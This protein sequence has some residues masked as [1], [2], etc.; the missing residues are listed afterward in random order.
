MKVRTILILLISLI[1][2]LF[3]YFYPSN[4]FSSNNTSYE[5]I[6]NPLDELNGVIVYSNG[7]NY[8][9]SHG[10]HYHTDGYYFG[11][12][13]QCVEFVKR[14]YYLH[15]KHKMP[16]LYG[17]A[18]SF[19]APNV[20]HGKLNKDR[21]LIQYKNGGNIPPQINDLIVFEYTQYGHVAIISQVEDTSIEIT[22]QNT[23]RRTREKL[24]L[25]KQK[26][27]YFVG[28]NKTLGW[29]RKKN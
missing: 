13:W 23:G 27:N 12:K 28:D 4:Q 10:K 9:Q 20:P 29:L 5:G 16:N 8:S 15:L 24:P 17:H 7:T 19:F 18:I 26:G 3:Y 14:Y 6:G 2:I 1:A 25:L 21:N 11:H 22:Q